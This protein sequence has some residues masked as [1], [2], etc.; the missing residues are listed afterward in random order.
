MLKSL[1]IENYALI[2][3]LH[4][5][6]DKG[7]TV[8]S[9]ETGA[10]KSII[11][12]ALSL[13]LGQRADSRYVKS[14]ENKCLIEGMLDISSYNLKSFFE[15]NDWVYDGDECILR[16]EVWANGKSRAFVN[17]S[18]VYLHDMKHLGDKLI[19]VHSQHKNLSLNDNLF[20]LNVIDTLANTKN[21]LEIYSKAYNEYRET[22]KDLNNFKSQ[23]RKNKEEEDFLR[24]QYTALSEANLQIDEQEILEAE[25]E[26]ITHSEEIKSGLF[27]ITTLMSEGENNLESQLGAIHDTLQKIENVFP[28][29]SELKERVMTAYIDL[30][31]VREEASGYFEEIDFDPDRQQ[32][33]EDRLSLIYG[34]QKKHSITSVSQLIEYRDEMQKQLSNIDSL[35]E[36]LANLEK[37]TEAKRNVMF[38]AGTQLSSK[39][40][41][42]TSEIETELIKR[43]SYLK[44][45]NAGFKCSFK[46]KKNPD[47]TGIDEIQ[48]LFSANKNTPLQPVSEIAS[49]G[50]ISRLMLCLK[51]MIAGATSLP[52][53]LFD[54]IDTGTSGDIAD[55]L[56]NIMK[57]MSLDMQ[58][59]SITHLPQIASKG[60]AHLLVYKN[61]TENE[62]NT[63]IKV[64]TQQE[65]VDEIARMLSGS[66]VSAE[67]IE[68]ARVMLSL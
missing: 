43:L 56:G 51:A 7:F 65:R 21:E 40:K 38:S 23:A 47:E 4:I 48:F 24:F 1:S 49:G 62:V 60:D 20:Q 33:L 63:N 50:E 52:T 45:M 41:S 27:E 44:I 36:R 67:A 55:R 11:L 35:D 31:D 8:I 5:A 34:L 61:E 59:I 3:S 12:G 13:I 42:I 28:K 19:D 2:D 30:K 26:T 68:N 17:D 9:G 18:P 57:K 64:L 16:R 14:G 10:G 15:D 39:R 32:Y 53:I 54:E 58:V 25:L 6:F 22:E 37:E 29:V 66:E 46:E